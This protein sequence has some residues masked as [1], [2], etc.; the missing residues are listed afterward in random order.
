M[1]FVARREKRKKGS[2]REGP[3]LL[4][5][6]KGKADSQRESGKLSKGKEKGGWRGKAR[7]E[8]GRKE[9][10]H[11]VVPSKEKGGHHRGA[12]AKRRKGG[13]GK[14]KK[15]KTAPPSFAEKKEEKEKA[16]GA[17]AC[18]AEEEERKGGKRDQRQPIH[19]FKV[20]GRGERRKGGPSSMSDEKEF[21]LTTV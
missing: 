7:H 15:E 18:V 20:G 17:T 12:D 10:K 2:K 21:L 9:R 6:L 8:G 4:F 16:T 14:R 1:D 11:P 13:G 5:I 19:S 3:V